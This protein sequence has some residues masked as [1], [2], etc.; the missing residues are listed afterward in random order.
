MA[1]KN[2]KEILVGLLGLVAE[3]VLYFFT[4]QF[5]TSL[6]PLFRSLLSGVPLSTNE[7]VVA[8][9]TVVF[10]FTIAV[11]TFLIIRRIRARATIDLTKKELKEAFSPFEDK[12]NVV[13]PEIRKG[14][15]AFPL[16]KDIQKFANTLKQ[17]IRIIDHMYLGYWSDN[18]SNIKKDPKK[19]I[20]DDKT[21][22][23]LGKF[24]LLSSKIT[25]LG[26][27]IAKTFPDPDSSRLLYV[28]DSPQDKER[29]FSYTMKKA[30]D[31]EV[32]NLLLAGDEILS[33][34]KQY[35]KELDEI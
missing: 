16:N 9:L 13:S 15:L 5:V 25:V 24:G 35:L 21:L 31:K 28:S 32:A 18:R 22:A 19:E 7:Y 11:S 14:F 3:A 8:S 30:D 26:D 29:Q 27:S 12:W 6:V 20:D 1:P 4:D 10:T 2:P 33:D 34:C 23:V 17:R